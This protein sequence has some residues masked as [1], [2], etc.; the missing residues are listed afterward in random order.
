MTAT[1]DNFTKLKTQIVEMEA[2]INARL[3]NIEDRLNTRFAEV[4]G[5]LAD[6]RSELVFRRWVFAAIIGLQI[7]ILAKVMLI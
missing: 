7:T 6:I 3:T 2:R 5:H 1:N 4:E